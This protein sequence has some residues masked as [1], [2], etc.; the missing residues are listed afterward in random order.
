[1]LII[2]NCMLSSYDIITESFLETEGQEMRDMAPTVPLL[3]SLVGAQ[4]FSIEAN[5]YLYCDGVTPNRSL[6]YLVKY[7]DVLNPTISDTS[8]T[9]RLG[10]FCSS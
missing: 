10:S 4:C 5:D 7:L 8:E 1:M 2:H 3:T 9:V 6:K